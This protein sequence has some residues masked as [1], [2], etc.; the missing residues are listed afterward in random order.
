MNKQDKI[1]QLKAIYLATDPRFGQ[2]KKDEEHLQRHLGEISDKIDKAIDES[3]R[4]KK[5]LMQR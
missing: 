5:T 4:H 3:L 2:R 1:E